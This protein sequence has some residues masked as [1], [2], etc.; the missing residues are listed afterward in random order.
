MTWPM[1]LAADTIEKV[2]AGQ[3]ASFS[4]HELV[5]GRASAPDE[6][7]R[8]LEIRAALDYSELEPGQRATDAIRQ[9]A[10]DLD[11]AS[12]YQAQPA[13]DRPGADGGRG[14]RDDQRKCGAQRHRDDCGRARH[15][16]AGAALGAHHFCGVRLPCRRT[17]HHRRARH[18]DG[19][20]AQSDIGLFCGAV[21]RS[22]R[23]LR[24]AVQRPLSRRAARDRQSARGALAIGQAR[25]RAVDACGIGDGGRLLL[26]P[27]DGLQG[28]FR[29]RP[30]RRRRHA[31]R[32]RHQH[33]AVAGAIK[34]AQAAERAVRRSATRCSRRSTVSL[35]SIA[36]RS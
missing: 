25:R 7:L 24:T 35:P 21:R 32:V 10:A 34:P 6:L 1:T 22:R 33:H 3:P 4:W 9:A 8:F 17:F 36:C 5:E 26:V 29:T 23:R 28:R 12:K 15:S 27:A 11:F 13:A 16:V 31:D 20:Y 14:V 30:Y 19:R 18:A 2:N